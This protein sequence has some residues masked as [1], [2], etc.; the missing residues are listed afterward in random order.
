VNVLEE[1]LPIL[2]NDR[3]RGFEKNRRNPECRSYNYE[4]LTKLA[5]IISRNCVFYKVK[6]ICYHKMS[7]DW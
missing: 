4:D 3:S 7:I 2:T 6:R 5:Q 1:A